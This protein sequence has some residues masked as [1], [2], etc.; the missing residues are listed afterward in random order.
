[1]SNNAG[2][3]KLVFLK[4]IRFQVLFPKIWI[5]KKKGL[6]ISGSNSIYR[7]WSRREVR[8]NIHST[9][10]NAVDFIH[11]SR[12]SE[13]RRLGRISRTGWGSQ[14]ASRHRYISWSRCRWTRRRE[15]ICIDSHW[16]SHCRMV[17]FTVGAELA[18]AIT[19]IEFAQ[20]FTLKNHWAG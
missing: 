17:K 3:W 20:F 13:K 19:R 10:G 1:V 15:T 2:T 6:Y 7:A 5:N 18:D 9:W 16:S 14:K 12:S 8:R 11:Q 4:F